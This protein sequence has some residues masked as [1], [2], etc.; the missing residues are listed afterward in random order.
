MRTSFEIASLAARS[1]TSAHGGPAMAM[2][3]DRTAA[4]LPTSECPRFRAPTRV[5]SCTKSANGIAHK[6]AAKGPN[7]PSHRGARWPR[8]RQARSPSDTQAKAGPG[9]VDEAGRR[10]E[11]DTMSRTLSA[12]SGGSA[13]RASS[14][15]VGCSELTRHTKPLPTSVHHALTRLSRSRSPSRPSARHSLRIVSRS[16]VA[17]AAHADSPASRISSASKT[18]LLSLL[19]CPRSRAATACSVAQD[20]WRRIARVRAMS[21]APA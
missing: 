12:R 16:P 8:A 14:I 5:T 17:K 7:S 21:R 11:P 2:A 9:R 13:T 18:P 3:R 1:M 20:D 19:D 4:S 10:G 15:H 6:L